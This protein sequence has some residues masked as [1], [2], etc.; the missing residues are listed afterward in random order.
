[1]AEELDVEEL[2]EA[3]YNKTQ[4]LPKVE[5]V[6]VSSYKAIGKHIYC[7]VFIIITQKYKII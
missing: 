2:L 4:P 3:T 1:M 6:I 5:D 7:T